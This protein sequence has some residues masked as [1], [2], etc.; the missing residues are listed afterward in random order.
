MAKK[1]KA[2]SD[3]AITAAVDVKQR[4]DVAGHP[5]T[6]VLAA[7]GIAYPAQMAELIGRDISVEDAANAPMH[8]L[9]HLIS[10]RKRAAGHNSLGDAR[11]A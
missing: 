5:L 3:P 10:T 6:S 11:S 2:K 9:I 1:A 7:R 8:H 4:D